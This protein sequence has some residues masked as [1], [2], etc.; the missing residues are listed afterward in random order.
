M[1]IYIAVAIVAIALLAGAGVLLLK[2]LASGKVGPNRFALTAPTDARR[3]LDRGAAWAVTAEVEVPRNVSVAW[4]QALN[5]PLIGLAPLYSGPSVDGATRTYR[6]VVAMTTSVV[7]IVGNQTM[8]AVGTGVS[9][10]FVVKHIAEEV[11][12]TARGADTSVVA[13]TV[14]VHPRFIG[15]LPLRWTAVFVRPF[16][17]FALRRAF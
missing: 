14:A 7:D 11:V 3:F 15:F 16:L 9:V 13:Y 4:K 10:P 6:G 12:V 17:A 5:G 2:V 8:V 1:W